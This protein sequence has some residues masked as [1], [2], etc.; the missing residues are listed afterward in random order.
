MPIPAPLQSDYVTA[1]SHVIR[2]WSYG[3]LQR[4]RID[5]PTNDDRVVG[6]L[7]DQRIFGPLQ[8][9]KCACGEY[10]G[11][12]YVGMICDHC[13]VK[14]GPSTLR[15]LRFGHIELNLSIPHPFDESQLIDC[16]PVLPARYFESSAGTQ[17]AT[18]YDELVRSTRAAQSAEAIQGILTAIQEILT[19]V[20]VTAQNWNLPITSTL[21]RGIA[22]EHCSESDAA[23]SYC[24]HCGYLLEGL[25]S[26]NCPGCGQPLPRTEFE[27]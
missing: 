9:F 25:Q 18:L 4:P 7:H 17:L 24:F 6:T 19:P 5:S 27:P 11:R 21:A 16:F 12:R 2:C 8:D 10:E 20:V 13:G 26:Y 1:S 23:V 14:I 15:S 22:L 3:E